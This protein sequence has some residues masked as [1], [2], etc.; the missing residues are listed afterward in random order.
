MRDAL[1]AFVIRG[2][3][4]NIAF[5]SALVAHPRFVSGQFTTAFIAEEYPKGF[6]PADLVHDNPEFLIAVAAAVHRTYR[7]A[8]RG[9]RAR[10]PATSC[11]S[12]TTIS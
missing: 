11:T 12:A 3:A 6:S 5:Q 7:D 8:R 10:S 9:L 4:S 1:N 2:P